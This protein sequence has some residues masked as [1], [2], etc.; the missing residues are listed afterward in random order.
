MLIGNNFVFGKPKKIYY[1]DSHIFSIDEDIEGP[2]IDTE[3]LDATGKKI[4]EIK[5]NNLLLCNP[6]FDKKVIKRDHI[7]IIDKNGEIIIESRVFNKDT[8]IISG[9]FVINNE[10]LTITQNYVFFLME[11]E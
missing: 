10:I 2:Y 4:I 11:K 3:L 5:K 1:H 9:K 8:I 6:E 7:L